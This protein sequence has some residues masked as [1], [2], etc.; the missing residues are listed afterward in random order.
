MIYYY[1][2]A[3][4]TKIKKNIKVISKHTIYVDNKWRGRSQ[5]QLLRRRRWTHQAKIWLL[6][7]WACDIL[8]RYFARYKFVTYLL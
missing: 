7:S 1:P 6:R 4:K 8:T 3:I 5:N 2:E